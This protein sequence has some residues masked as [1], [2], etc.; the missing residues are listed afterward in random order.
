MELKSEVLKEELM[1]VTGLSVTA[2]PAM[3]D[4][5]KA[6]ASGVAKA[7]GVAQAA[8]DERDEAIERAEA[9]EAL[10]AKVRPSLDLLEKRAQDAEERAAA[11]EE[12]GT[13][14]KLRELV[15]RQRVEK[16]ADTDTVRRSVDGVAAALVQ[17][18]EAIADLAD[19]TKLLCAVHA[20]VHNE[21][22]VSAIRCRDEDGGPWYVKSADGTLVNVVDSRQ[23]AIAQVR[24]ML[25]RSVPG[26]SGPKDY[27]EPMRPR[28]QPGEIRSMDSIPR[29]PT[30]GRLDGRK[31]R[32]RRQMRRA[33]IL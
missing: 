31:L 11:A 15:E 32:T 17:R 1:K 6:C 14:V 26:H 5:V 9:A 2:P 30:G 23:V 10:V 18:G 12:I 20:Q 33:R 27:R 22:G 29:S 21:D 28:T 3:R 8:E 25:A 13:A 16:I 4:V 7:L 19:V 24:S